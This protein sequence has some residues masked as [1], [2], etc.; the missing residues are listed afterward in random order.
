MIH[1]KSWK[2]PGKFGIGVRGTREA[3]RSRPRPRILGSGVMECW[4]A[5][6]ATRSVAGGS[7]GV[8]RFVRIAPRV[9]EVG[10]HFQGV[11]LATDD[12][13]LEALGYDL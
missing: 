7:T 5:R 8:L 2:R 9:R 10:R 11:F 1:F 13:G 12:P 3:L 4:P 6:I